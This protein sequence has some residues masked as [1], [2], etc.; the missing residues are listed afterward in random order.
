MNTYLNIVSLLSAQPPSSSNAIA[1]KIIKIQMLM[2]SEHRW[3]KYLHFKSFPAT[4]PLQLL[5]AKAFPKQKKIYYKLDKMDIWFK[6][7]VR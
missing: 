2:H 3:Q 6:W 1:E 5:D 7:C 4:S